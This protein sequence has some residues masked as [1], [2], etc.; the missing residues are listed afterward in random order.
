MSNAKIAVVGSANMDFFA[1][2]DQIPE[3][4]ETVIGE[5]YIMEMG[6][7]GANQAVGASRLCAKSSMVGRV[8]NDLFGQKM[9]DTL[10]NHGVSCQ[11]MKVDPQ[12]GSGVALVIVHKKVDNI[13]VVVPGANMQ[14]HPSD[15]TEAS[16]AIIEADVLL[17]QL[18]VPLEVVERAIDIA[19][20]HETLCILNPAP[21]R[22]LPDSILRKVQLLTPN[23][24]EAKALTGIQA[25]SLEGAE[26]AGRALLDNGVKS[27]ILTL[28]SQGAMIVRPEKTE[29]VPGIS[30]DTIDTTGAGDAFMAGLGVGL[31]EGKS[32]DE[33][34]DFANI[35]GALTT[36]KA[37]AMPALPTRDEVET[38]Y[39]SLD[40]GS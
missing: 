13:V 25:D 31:A 12:V 40:S 6:G 19:L 38:L 1:F 26:A 33:A 27:V 4:G 29:H 34:V 32:L 11:H 18:E 17:L 10:T 24:S 36:T 39:Q 23:Q 20:D 2:T 15:V 28:G 35:V 5:E 7:K 21:A 9:L 8:G 30:V 14:V 3:I 16:E 22:P 37:G